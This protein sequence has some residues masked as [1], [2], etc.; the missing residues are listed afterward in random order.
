MSPVTE[1]TV[2]CA[3][4]GAPMTLRESRYGK[5]WGCTRFPA[6][7]GIH[8]AH[9][10]NGAPFGRPADKATRQA[11]IRAHAAFDQ[12]WKDGHLSRN[13][14]YRWLQEKLGITKNECHIALFDKAMCARVIEECAVYQDF[15]KKLDKAK[16]DE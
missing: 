15:K 12:I 13:S 6:C 5:F 16:A 3:E 14:A 1:N 4:C 10:S 7:K 2:N 11:R 8:G 9:Q